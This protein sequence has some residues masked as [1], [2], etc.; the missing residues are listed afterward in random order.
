M[1]QKM[2]GA[3]LEPGGVAPRPRAAH[4]L[5]VAASAR[6]A[7]RNDDHPL[8]KA[9]NKLLVWD[10]EKRPPSPASPSRLLNPV[11]GKSLVVYATKPRVASAADRLDPEGARQCLTPSPCPRS[12][13][14]SPPP[15]WPSTVDAIAAWQLPNG[16]IPWFPGGHAD[17]WNHVEAAMALALGGRTAE[18]ERAYQ[19]LVDIQ[20]PDGSWHQYYLADRVEQDKLDANTI[21]YIAAGVWHHWLRHRR[22]RLRRGDVADRSRRPSTSCSTC[23]RPAA[24]SSGPATPTARRGRSP[25]SPARRRICHTP[26]LRHRP[27]RALGHERPDWELIGRPPRPRHPAHCNGELPDAFA[28]K[29]RW[30]M[31]WYYPVLAG[32]L[33]GDDGP[34]P[35]RRP[36]R[37]VRGRGHGRALRQRPPVDHRGRDLRVPARPPRRSASA[38][39]AATLFEWAQ[40]LRDDDGHYWTGI[41]FPEE[42]HFPGDEQSTYTAAVGRARRRRP[43]RHLAGRRGLFADHDACCPALIDAE[44]GRR[45]QHWTDRQRALSATRAGRQAPGA[46]PCG[47]TRSEPVARTSANAPDSSARQ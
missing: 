29:H 34:R 4:A 20:R 44:P 9:Y 36:P 13:A 18:A 27:R 47:R 41:V 25:C 42:V 30:A 1:R 31:D 7:P 11:L 17:P 38:S 19:W 28:P 32:V 16:M 23:R 43:R 3:G 15:R 26:A 46:G 8:V 12:P 10:I 24:R 22:P 33:R 45:P 2:R 35:P 40:H 37:H 5:L 39:T 6:S 21:A 14:S